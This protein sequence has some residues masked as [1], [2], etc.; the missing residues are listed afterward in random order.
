MI[1]YNFPP[2]GNAGAYRPLRF[3]Q[4]LPKLG[5]LPTVI[6][7]IP[8]QYERYDVV[9]SR[10][11]PD[12]IEVIRINGGDL[13]QT[14]QSW[15]SGRSI[16]G[17]VSTRSDT[18]TKAANRQQSRFRYWLREMVRT[19]E[20][21]FY[22]P[23]MASPWINSAVDAA[24]AVCKRKPVSVI[25]ATAGPVSSFYVARLASQK[26]GVPYMLDFRDAWTITHSDFEARRPLWATR[27]DRRQM[28]DLLR[29]A[30]AV[31][32]R[33]DTEAECFWRAYR[34]AMDA[35][36]VNLIPNGFEAPI[37]QFAALQEGKCIILYT[38][39]VLDYRYDTL[40]TALNLLKHSQPDLAKHLCLRFVGEG[41]DVIANEAA[42][43]GL[44]DII[45]TSGPKPYSEVA[46]LQRE[47]HALLVLGRPA[48]KKGFELFAAAKLF[49]YL[50]AGR[51]IFGVLP[52]DESRKVLL[53]V[54]ARTIADVN[55]P[56]EIIHVLR[57]L[58]DNWSAGTL[59]SLV[60]DA[61][62][63]Q[64]YSSKRQTGT[65]VR[66]LEGVPADAPFV[67]GAQAIPP[68]LRDVIENEDWLNGSRLGKVSGE[69]AV[70][71]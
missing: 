50:K 30:Q 12:E 10:M 43:L 5:W 62:A 41:M 46:R 44:S 3:V 48:T 18:Y 58:L 49:G 7:A 39:I 68:S 69:R 22:H 29:H 67:P 34:G 14:F 65:L 47:A 71:R 66:A 40:L 11:V 36:R 33:Y 9:L 17:S 55:S 19:A 27:R 1:A 35:S 37:E 32:F 57:L 23:D 61:K 42:A 38:G 31:T 56:S 15:R 20:A 63:C 51:P 26:T 64:A 59:S 6:S 54:G 28:Y 8:P 21:W 24:V 4:Q 53:R 13:W 60:P 25:W 16:S 2:E 45:E 52:E 70:T